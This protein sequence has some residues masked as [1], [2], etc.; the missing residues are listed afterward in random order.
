MIEIEAD[1]NHLRDKQKTCTNQK[2]SL[3]EQFLISSLFLYL[4]RYIFL[5]KNS[6]TDV[7]DF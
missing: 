1:T 2:S 3:E 7:I 6:L 5:N 4:S